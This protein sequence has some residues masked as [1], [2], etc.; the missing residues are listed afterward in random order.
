VTT[1]DA[2]VPD[3]TPADRHHTRIGARPTWSLLDFGEVWRFR[4]LLSSLALRDLKI[5]YK[6]TALGIIWVVF[7]PLVAT[8]IFVYIRGFFGLNDNGTT[9]AVL[10]VL[11]GYVAFGLFKDS[12]ERASASLV[13]NSAL[14]SKIYFPRVLLPLAAAA[15]AV[16]D[17]MVMLVMVVLAWIACGILIG[18]L[19]YGPENTIVPVP[20]W[21]LLMWPVTTAVLLMLAVGVGMTATAL[22]SH[23]RDFK[24]VVP[25]A[26]QL[27]L[28]AS[29]V[30]YDLTTALYGSQEAAAAAAAAGEP[31]PWTPFLFNPMAGALDTYRWAL[32]GEGTVHWLA[33][34]YSATCAAVMLIVG[35]LVFRRMEGKVAD[36]I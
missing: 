20:G 11:A 7:Q 8:A 35:M 22:A 29:P 13:N 18:W 4:E 36:V 34:A 2:T 26:L 31:L 21:H 6:Q 3:S 16:F 12:T 5:R 27:L 28:Y 1:L 19:G 15:S 33:F 10:F 9:P 25:V 32:V 17:H 14:V 24:H 30:F 23:F